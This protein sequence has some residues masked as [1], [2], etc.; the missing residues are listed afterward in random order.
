MILLKR[1]TPKPRGAALLFEKIIHEGFSTFSRSLCT[2]KIGTWELREGLDSFP[3]IW[4]L[5]FLDKLRLK[6]LNHVPVNNTDLR[7][8]YGIQFDRTLRF[9][10]VF[11][12]LRRDHFAKR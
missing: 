5:D 8:F 11:L 7:R 3:S 1:N 12:E 10:D 9:Q 2:A 4:T 6:N